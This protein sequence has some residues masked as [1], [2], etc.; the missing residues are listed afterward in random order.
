MV[1]G[2]SAASVAVPTVKDALALAASAVWFAA[3]VVLWVVVEEAIELFGWS[4]AMGAAYFVGF[5]AYLGH[6]ER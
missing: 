2:G 6:R 4:V 3:N 5:F 1:G